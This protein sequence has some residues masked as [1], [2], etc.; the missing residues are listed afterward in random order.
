[1]FYWFRVLLCNIEKSILLTREVEPHSIECCPDSLDICCLTLHIWS[2][3][4]IQVTEISGNKNI[5]IVFDQVVVFCAFHKFVEVI[6]IF[7][8]FAKTKDSIHRKIEV[9]TCF[10]PKQASLVVMRMHLIHELPVVHE[11]LIVRWA[12]TSSQLFERYLR[13][14]F[15]RFQTMLHINKHWRKVILLRVVV[16]GVF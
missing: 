6:L 8:G 2:D 5:D 7:P 9:L 3:W 11:K 15:M 4:F 16:E 13:N 10:R 12:D 14:L 1:M